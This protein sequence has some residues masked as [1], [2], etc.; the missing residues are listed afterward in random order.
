MDFSIEQWMEIYLTELKKTFGERIWFVGLQGSY[1]R[2][3]ADENR[4]IDMVAILDRIGPED[5][6]LYGKMLYK[7]PCSEKTCGFISGKAELFAWEKSDLFQ[8]CFD[9]KPVIGSLNEIKEKITITDVLRAV[10]IGA[11]NVYHGCSHNL[12]HEKSL[13]ILK[14]LYKSAVFTLQAIVFLQNGE[15]KHKKEELIENLYGRDRNILENSLKLKRE[16]ELS[17]EE[18]KNIS[19]ELL[20]WASYWIYQ[21]EERKYVEK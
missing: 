7:L 17:L 16:K 13:D 2:G 10:R 3:E 15:Y 14:G 11:C 21:S 4:D 8:F 5:L 19:K 18:F 9:T 1:G 6:E 12:V 20:L